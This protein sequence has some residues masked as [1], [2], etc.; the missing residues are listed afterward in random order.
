M[1]EA[2]ELNLPSTEL[3]MPLTAKCAHVDA[4]NYAKNILNLCEWQNQYY[5]SE[6]WIFSK[7]PGP[8]GKQ[9]CL[10]TR[11]NFAC[12]C[13][14]QV[15]TEDVTMSTYG[16]D[17]LQENQSGKIVALEGDTNTI[18]TQ[19]RLLPPSQKILILPNVEETITPET[20][21]DAFNARAFIR[22]LQIAVT[23]RTET[24]RSFLQ[25]STPTQPRLVFTVHGNVSARTTCITKISQNLTS[26]SVEEAESIF[27]DLVKDGIA[28]LSELDKEEKEEGN[29]A[30]V[31]QDVIDQK[32][33][34]EVVDNI[35]DL[36]QA[37]ESRDRDAA[38]SDSEGAALEPLPLRSISSK[39][40]VMSLEQGMEPP[41][42][43]RSQASK[44]PISKFASP[45]SQPEDQIV[46]TVLTMPN[47]NTTLAEKR[48]TFGPK[49]GAVQ[50]NRR[51]GGLSYQG[52]EEIDLDDDSY[53]LSPGQHSVM[54]VPTTP[55]GVVYGEA[56][57]V[58][59]QSGSPTKSL[60]KARSFDK[61][62]SSDAKL[63]DLA[64]NA[65]QL[66][67]TKSHYHLRDNNPALEARGD[68][69]EDSSR[70]PTLPRTT[71][72]KASETTIKKSP[73]TSTRSSRSSNSSS[74]PIG[75][76]TPAV[77]VEQET[78][79][80]DHSEK[81]ERAPF[82]AVFELLE[83]LVIHFTDDLP[84][85]IF[86]S[87]VRS[88]KSGNY[89]IIPPTPPSLMP[90]KAPSSP[91]TADQIQP[92]PS[93]S[94]RSISSMQ[95]EVDPNVRPSSHLTAETDDFR[96]DRQSFDP[97]SDES[98]PPDIRRK[99]PPVSHLRILESSISSPGLPTP[100]MET[101]MET[102]PSL[103]EDN[104]ENLLENRFVD[105]SPVNIRDPISVQNSFR[106][107]LS[108]LF[109]PS[110][111]YSQYLYPVPSEVE[112]LWKPVF[113]N[114]E[115]GSHGIEG[116]NVDQIIAYGCEDGV[117]KDFFYQISGQIEKTGMKKDGMNR[118]GKLDIRYLI[119]NVMQSYMS[120]S[121]TREAPNP[122]SDPHVLA[123][124]LVPHIEAFLAGNSSTRLLI[125]HF[126]AAN[127]PTVIALQ[128]L[129][130]TDLFRIAGIL[131]TLA[132]D[133][134]S[135]AR[136]GSS[137]S[138]KSPFNG[139]SKPASQL[140]KSI[141]SFA[142]AD[143]LLPSIATDTEIST[144]LSG[145]W[146]VLMEKS[147]FY[148]P[149][150]EP[151]PI[152]IERPP[153]PPTPTSSMPRDRDSGY[154]SSS[155][156]T[157]RVSKAS[158][159]TGGGAPGTPRGGNYPASINSVLSK[160]NSGG[161][162]TSVTAS[163]TNTNTNTNRHKYAASIA[164]TKTTGSERERKQGDKEWENFYIEDDDSEDD[165]YDKMIL[166]R[167]MQRI[168]PEVKKPGQKANTKKALKWLGLA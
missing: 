89:P 69:G 45:R 130:G 99:W 44:I 22:D 86:E 132:S 76:R 28:G 36:Q 117:K 101:P 81:S 10:L 34:E 105:F 167:Q 18:S 25:L 119:S 32:G 97:Y 74:K 109:P 165:A 31:N 43:G 122:I 80:H 164:S 135:I 113:R 110:E 121:I 52:E 1:A 85:E 115:N 55:Y 100:P 148:T 166:G 73:A 79:A 54:S 67:Q 17:K 139:R 42:K 66:K 50:L 16:M 2:T 91:V 37:F 153:I 158:R 94:P 58:D 47:R 93:L 56:C 14:L 48:S 62:H 106:E 124:L 104:E 30:E 111:N 145:I 61:L 60:R 149:E 151:K 116:R 154:P 107:L 53:L 131:D 5:S 159:L 15:V 103:P 155:N 49:L 112:R 143:Y 57:L 39:S 126:S 95:L 72:V 128:G 64:S 3:T 134:P 114:E 29:N 157:P 161:Y 8:F 144:F 118:S 51:I 41:K 152:I 96:Y 13:V 102:E 146:K 92:K 20:A 71:F 26:G 33:K 129:L 75:L 147:S 4:L 19:L 9:N 35:E 90:S 162:A 77:D 24:A 38:I 150:P 78:D 82:V 168:V 68:K 123:S 137:M 108:I 141:T 138:S 7:V 11:R 133:P 156:Q 70:F 160:G 125:L 46:T 63:Q 83:D 87:V 21:D 163:T 140:A 136:P 23:Q 12:D 6:G 40:H 65:H 120:S 142:R 59:M 98:Y 84:N 27:N 127:L 88:Y